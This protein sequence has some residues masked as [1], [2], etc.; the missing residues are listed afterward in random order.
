MISFIFTYLGIYKFNVKRNYD[1]FV[2]VQIVILLAWNYITVL[3]DILTV[4][5]LV[6]LFLISI[7][8][9]IGSIK[10]IFGIPKSYYL[11]SMWEHFVSIHTCISIQL[12]IC[13]DENRLKTILIQNFFDNINKWFLVICVFVC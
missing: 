7:N 2:F 8:T 3:I 12:Y 1:V 13:N 6:N 4:Y 11:C 10:Y 5:C 9:T